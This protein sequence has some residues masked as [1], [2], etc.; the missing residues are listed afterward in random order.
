M[1]YSV[2]NFIKKNCTGSYNIDALQSF[3]DKVKR[4]SDGRY[5]NNSALKIL[6][7]YASVKD[8]LIVFDV[9]SRDSDKTLN[10]GLDILEKSLHQTVKKL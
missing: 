3:A 4:D 2:K 7:R 6:C 1:S 10:E 8:G 9:N 5:S